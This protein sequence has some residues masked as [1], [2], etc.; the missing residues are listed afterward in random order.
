METAKM[1]ATM[2]YEMFFSLWVLWRDEDTYYVGRIARD[3]ENHWTVDSEQYAEWVD[4][5]VR[6]F[7]LDN[8]RLTNYP[9]VL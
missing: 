7:Y 5:F 9:H 8:S 1:Q 4:R 2:S 3:G 6:S